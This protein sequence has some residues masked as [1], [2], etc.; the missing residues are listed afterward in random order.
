MGR[1]KQYFED[2]WKLQNQRKTIGLTLFGVIFDNSSP[3]SPGN[4]LI[5]AE[6]AEV[7]LQMLAQKGY[8]IIIITGQPPSRTKNLEIVDFENI[9]SATSEIFQ[10]MGCRI[11][12][13]YFA[14]STDKNDPYVKPNIG[15]FER[16]ANENQIK[17]SETYYIGVESNDVKAAVKAGATPVIVRNSQNRDIKFKALEMTNNTKIQ[18]VSSLTDFVSQLTSAYSS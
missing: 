10:K 5:I 6:G 8:D 12:N 15:M 14:P 9:L 17:W 4:Q 1:Y 11:K 13:A 2:I 3:F 18:E 7:G 16:A